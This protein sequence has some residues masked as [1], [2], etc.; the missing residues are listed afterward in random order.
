MFASSWSKQ[1]LRR[2]RPRL[3]VLEDRILPTVYWNVDADGSWDDPNNWI[4][5]A[6]HVRAPSS[7]DDVII[8]RG[9][10]TFTITVPT[11][12]A[13]NSITSNETVIFSGGTVYGGM[14]QGNGTYI[15]QGATLTGV[16]VAAA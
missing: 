1:Q 7:G 16:T 6:N 14:I 4:D 11:G 3:E 12:A 2:F 8:D 10:G 15:L 5:Q 9:A 13:P